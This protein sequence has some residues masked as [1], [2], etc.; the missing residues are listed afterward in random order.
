MEKKLTSRGASSGCRVVKQPKLETSPQS[1]R[2]ERK[3]RDTGL[4]DGFIGY[5]V[6]LATAEV[7]GL[8][9]HVIERAGTSAAKNGKLIA[10]FIDGAVAVDSFGDGQRGLAYA[11]WRSVLALDA[12]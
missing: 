9:L 6:D 4:L 2:R 3:P 1:V 8:G 5:R 7:Q 11:P 10:G 12:G